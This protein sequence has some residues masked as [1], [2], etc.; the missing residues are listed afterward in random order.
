MS[1]QSSCQTPAP[2]QVERSEAAP[3]VP[4]GWYYLPECSIPLYLALNLT[5]L[6]VELQAC[7]MVEQLPEL[8]FCPSGNWP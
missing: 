7:T 5:L 4:D 2:A 1:S 6:L 3:P 8:V